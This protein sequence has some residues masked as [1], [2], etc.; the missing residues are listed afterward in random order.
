[1][2]WPKWLKPP[3]Q[4][5]EA[6]AALVALLLQKTAEDVEKGGKGAGK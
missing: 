6:F 3:K 5:R 1:M 2:V 4:V